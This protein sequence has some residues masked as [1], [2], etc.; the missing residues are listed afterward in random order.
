[1][2]KHSTIHELY[3]SAFP[4]NERRPWAEMELLEM[5]EK[6][7]TIKSISR[8][9][10]FCGFITSWNFDDFVY[11]EHF[12]VADIVRGKGVGS[13][14]ID[15]FCNA[16]QR[17]VVLEVETPKTTQAIRRIAFYERH[18]FKVVS[19]TY[20]QPPYDKKSFYLPM[21]LMCNDSTFG[22]KHFSRIKNTIY[23]EVYGVSM[24]EKM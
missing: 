10:T 5:N 9:G 13:E 19:Q 11:V 14:I 1:M 21:L 18:G 6:R 7:F 15:D 17:P 8:D 12:A 16:A 3:H 4:A 20:M 24:P 22:E 23:T 2:E